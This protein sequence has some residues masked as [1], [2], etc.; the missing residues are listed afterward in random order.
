[1]RTTP[2]RAEDLHRRPHIAV[3]RAA[4]RVDLHTL[5][6][7]HRAEQPEHA[8]AQADIQRLASSGNPWGVSTATAAAFLRTATHADVITPPT[9]T[10]DAVTYLHD[11]LAL[12]NCR[13][14]DP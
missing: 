4:R 12:P 14:L 9:P 6:Q 2:K 13:L 3:E 11:L 10:L 1:M 5:L 7:A 8:A